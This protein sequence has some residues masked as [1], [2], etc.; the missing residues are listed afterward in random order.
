MMALAW[1]T[2]Q[3]IP[4]CLSRSPMTVLQPASTTPEPTNSGESG[5]TRTID[6]GPNL[7]AREKGDALGA[8]AWRC[9]RRFLQTVWFK[10][11]HF[12][13]ALGLKVLTSFPGPLAGHYR[14]RIHPRSH[15]RFFRTFPQQLLRQPHASLQ[16]LSLR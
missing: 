9:L 3:R 1:L 16:L 8:R 10:P 13:T 7:E 4:E 11:E 5:K 15:E 12:F 2:V 14:H 6:P